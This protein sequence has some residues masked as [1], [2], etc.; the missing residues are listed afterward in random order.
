MRSPQPYVPGA[1]ITGLAL[2][3]IFGEQV[4]VPDGHRL[5][6]L[7]FRRFA[8]C[9]I[10]D[11]HL[12][13]FKR[14]HGEIERANIREVVVFHSQAENIVTYE[15]D[16]PFALIGSRKASLRPIRRGKLAA[17]AAGSAPMAV[18]PCRPFAIAGE[19]PHHG[20]RRLP[21]SPRKADASCCPRTS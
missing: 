18:H 7:Q 16:L 5:T 2:T 14:R 11:L 9:P 1:Q 15:G 6:H 4:A 12:S 17:G 8:S 3:A 10:C 20:A 21:T 19:D 13:S